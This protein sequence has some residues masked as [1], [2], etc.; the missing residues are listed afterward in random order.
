M[1]DWWAEVRLATEVFLDRHGLLAAFAFLLVEEAG[2]PVPVLGATFL[3]A[4]SAWAG[5]GLVYRYGR[6]IHLS[7]QRLD[8]A[9]LWLQRHG[10]LAVVLG[11]LL[12]GFR[13]VTAVACGVFAVPVEIYV[14]A[15]S[16]GG[17]LYIVVYTL[18]G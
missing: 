11:R 1:V 16:L 2:V 5:R 13:I 14:P 12:P 18:L 7:P 4:L 9:G 10:F 8:R 6:F 3:Y 17:L 15:M